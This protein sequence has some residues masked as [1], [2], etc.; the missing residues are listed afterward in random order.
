MHLTS[1]LG[2]K[3]YYTTSV[4]HDIACG[5]YRKLPKAA[6]TVYTQHTAFTKTR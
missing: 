5:K 2:A 3:V 4:R 6:D 1:S